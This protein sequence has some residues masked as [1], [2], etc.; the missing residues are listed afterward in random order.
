MRPV[1]AACAS[2]QRLLGRERSR[3][4]ACA[5]ASSP[6]GRGPWQGLMCR[7]GGTGG[8]PRHFHLPPE[9]SRA[10]SRHSSSE[11]WFKPARLD[12]G[13]SSSLGVILPHR[14]VQV[15]TWDLG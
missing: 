1:L 7:R 6:K 4:G 15:E 13:Y 11:A 14:P 8:S 2:L 9:E 12:P 10:C 3:S 5:E